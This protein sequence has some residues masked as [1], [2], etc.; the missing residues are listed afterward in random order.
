LLEISGDTRYADVEERLML[1]HVFASQE[2]D[3]TS[4]RYHTRMALS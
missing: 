4:Y 1:N 2:V 3:G